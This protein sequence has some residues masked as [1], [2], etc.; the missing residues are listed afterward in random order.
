M[1]RA[2]RLVE[3]LTP[4]G[5]PLSR[6]AAALAGQALPP[7]WHRWGRTEVTVAAAPYIFTHPAHRFEGRM[8]GMRYAH[9]MSAFEIAAA[10]GRPPGYSA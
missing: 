3:R 2:F 4:C 8:A 9:P 10:Q 7:K 5:M 1:K 6:P